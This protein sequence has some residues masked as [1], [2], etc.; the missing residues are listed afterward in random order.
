MAD[1]GEHDVKRQR[2]DHPQSRGDQAIYGALPPKNLPKNSGFRPDL[3]P[4]FR[5]GFQLY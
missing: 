2:D 4:A 1:R 5:R 3:S